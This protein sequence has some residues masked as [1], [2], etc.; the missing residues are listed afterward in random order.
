MTESVWLEER[1]GSES[2]LQTPEGVFLV[3]YRKLHSSL[4]SGSI[5]VHQQEETEKK[6][7]TKPQ[8]L[9]FFVPSASF[10]PFRKLGKEDEK[11][12]F[13]RIQGPSEVFLLD[14]NPDSGRS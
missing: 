2:L 7:Q 11:H 14:L 1:L 3:L 12:N 10:S 13:A 6:N 9:G 5:L 4:V 8:I